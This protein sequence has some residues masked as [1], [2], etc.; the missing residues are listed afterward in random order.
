MANATPLCW[1]TMGK[2]KRQ[3]AVNDLVSYIWNLDPNIPIGFDTDDKKQLLNGAI[4]DQVRVNGITH[5]RLVFYLED[6]GWCYWIPAHKE[7]LL[8]Y[9]EHSFANAHVDHFKL[10]SKCIIPFEQLDGCRKK[11]PLASAIWYYVN[12]SAIHHWIYLQE[13]VDHCYYQ[14]I[15][16]L[17]N[18]E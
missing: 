11:P 9:L 14:D 15:C 18:D 5:T 16:K 2:K 1:D 7:E 12:V 4:M 3:R 10:F 8:G 13:Q 17:Y 6:V